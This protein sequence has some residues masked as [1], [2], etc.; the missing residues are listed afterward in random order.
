M[1]KASLEPTNHS[2]VQWRSTMV[3]VLRQVINLF[4]L[5][6]NRNT[7]GFSCMLA[8]PYGCKNTSNFKITRTKGFYLR[9]ETGHVFIAVVGNKSIRTLE[10]SMHRDIKT[11]LVI[12]TLCIVSKY[13]FSAFHGVGIRLAIGWRRQRLH[14]THSQQ[15]YICF[16]SHMAKSDM[17][18]THKSEQN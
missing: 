7:A 17:Q 11:H 14:F 4:Q 9:T 5:V 2:V 8:C 13:S 15:G 18:L 6:A 1:Y 12:Q 10:K 16:W 3:C